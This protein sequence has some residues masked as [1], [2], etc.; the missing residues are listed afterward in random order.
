MH[1]DAGVRLV[2]MADVFAGRVESRRRALENQNARQ[3]AVDDDHC[4]V[5]LDGYKGVIEASDVVLIANARR[6]GTRGGQ[7]QALNVNFAA[8]G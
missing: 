8:C 4:F 1:A 2:A 5:G 3:M 7:G 6:S